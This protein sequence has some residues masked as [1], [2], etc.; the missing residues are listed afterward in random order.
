MIQ[1]GS[2]Y[3]LEKEQKRSLMDHNLGAGMRARF[4]YV[5]FCTG[6]K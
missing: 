2:K 3:A 5:L 4:I 1:I 6:L